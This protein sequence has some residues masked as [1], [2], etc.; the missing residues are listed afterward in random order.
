MLITNK[1]RYATLAMF[2][3]ALRAEHDPVNIADIAQRHGISVSYLE[4]IFA[5]LRGHN[6]ITSMRGP[7]GGYRLARQPDTI[8][9]TEI[10]HLF[11]REESMEKHGSK[12]GPTDTGQMWEQ[13]DKKMRVFLG[14]LTLADLAPT[15]TPGQKSRSSGHARDLAPIA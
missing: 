7:G 13:L 11:D 15:A 12:T 4:Q 1:S 6:L 10:L 14:A 5:K 2:D 3:L 9:L 8:T